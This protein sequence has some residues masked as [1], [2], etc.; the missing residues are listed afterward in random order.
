MNDKRFRKY[1]SF[2]VVLTLLG[3]F[4]LEAKEEEKEEKKTERKKEKNAQHT[5][6]KVT[7]QAAKIFKSEFYR[8]FFTLFLWRFQRF[9]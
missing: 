6:G 8:H 4:E 7:T 3:M 2:S 1:C 5:L 9:P